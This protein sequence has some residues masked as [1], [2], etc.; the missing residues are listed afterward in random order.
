M[1]CRANPV[2]R[3]SSRIPRFAISSRH[4]R[5]GANPVRKALSSD[6]SFPSAATLP[7]GTNSIGLKII[8]EYPSSAANVRSQRARR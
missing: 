7:D 8:S 4:S 2:V 5:E 6:L 1:V 3:I